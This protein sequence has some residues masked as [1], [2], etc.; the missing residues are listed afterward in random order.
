[1]EEYLTV[2]GKLSSARTAVLRDDVAARLKQVGLSHAARWRIEQFSKGM[3]QR[4]SLAHALLSGPAFLILDEPMNG[5]DPAA[6][7][8]V[9]NLI[10]SLQQE[11]TTILF[12][13]HRLDDITDVCTHVGILKQG[14]LVRAG[15]L[16][17][18]L[19]LRDQIV[20]SVDR[21]P[22]ADRFAAL[23]PNT[24]VNGNTITLNGDAV[25][26]KTEILRRLID[27]GADIQSLSHRRAT[28]EEIY[29]EAMR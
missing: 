28:L 29:L 4:L 8:D 19:P 26:Y 5:L 15:A 27:A 11:G 6:Q 24:V 12:S 16:A 13:T 23:D 7:K 18:V 3:L 21:L 25:A 1:M 17:E 20:I 2:A 9:R 22:L 14:R 10:K